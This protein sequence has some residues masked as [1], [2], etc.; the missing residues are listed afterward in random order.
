MKVIQISGK[1]KQ[2]FKL[3]DLYAK[4]YPNKTLGE[5]AREVK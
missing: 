5:L 1:A 3:F 2:V 4:R